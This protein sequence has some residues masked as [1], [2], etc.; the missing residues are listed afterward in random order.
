MEREIRINMEID[1]VELATEI[2]ENLHP[3]DI[4][5]FVRIIN[6]SCED[7]IVTNKLARYFQSEMKEKEDDGGI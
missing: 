4:V 3:D 6:R 2:A 5:D 1:P 7:Q